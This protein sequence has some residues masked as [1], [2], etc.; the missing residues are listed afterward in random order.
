MKIPSREGK[1]GFSLQGWVLSF[2][3]THPDSPPNGGESHFH[4][5]WRR[6]GGMENSWESNRNLGPDRQGG[7]RPADYLNRSLTV[8]AQY[9][10]FMLCGSAQAAMDGSCEDPSGPTRGLTFSSSVVPPP[11]AR[12]ASFETCV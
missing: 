2:G 6:S 12:M 8:A 5:Q 10:I 7:E 3:T 9:R 4:A 11:A 1:E